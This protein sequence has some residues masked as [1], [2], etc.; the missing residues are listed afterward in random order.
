MNFYQGLFIILLTCLSAGRVH[1]QVELPEE[2]LAKESVVPRFDN[3]T[4]VKDRNVTLSHKF[5]TGIYYGWNFAEAINNQ[6]KLGLNLGY[7]WTETSAVLINYAMWQAGLNSQ[8]ASSL[9]AQGLNFNRAPA[10]QSSTWINYEWDIYYGKISITKQGVMNISVYP[11]GGIGMTTY[12]NK[13]YY[14]LD[15]GV[16]AKYYFSP[17]WALRTDFKVQ[18]SGQPSPFIAQLNP[19]L[20]PTPPTYSQFGDTNAIGT[21]LDIG[22]VAIF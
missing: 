14:G 13:S 22:L 8:Y 18:Y 3:P 9:S 2:E 19:S 5:E 7:H 15:A 16:G 4:T 20:Y 10:L 21:I 6:S 1:A 17:R 11:I 12:A